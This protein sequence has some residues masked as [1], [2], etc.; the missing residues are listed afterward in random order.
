MEKP[1]CLCGEL[2]E[3]MMDVFSSKPYSEAKDF[4]MALLAL[5]LTL[6][7]KYHITD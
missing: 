4:K 1:K 5:P 6:T 7:C 3:E 2:T